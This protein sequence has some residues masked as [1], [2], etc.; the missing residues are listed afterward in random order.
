VDRV[1]GHRAAMGLGFL[2]FCLI[3]RGLAYGLPT[4][5]PPQ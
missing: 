5:E 4:R 2:L 3:V 1:R